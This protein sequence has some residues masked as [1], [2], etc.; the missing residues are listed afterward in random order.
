MIRE[1]T[2]ADI[3]S[4]IALGEAMHRESR[5]GTVSWSTQKVG[6]L[7]TW[8]ISSDD[9]LVLV[10]ERDGEIIGGFLGVVTEHYFSTDKMAQDFALFVSPGR[11]G[12]VAGAQLLARFIA[13]A[14]SRGVMD[15]WIQVGVTT[16]VDIEKTSR[17]C[18][19][20]GFQPAGYLFALKE[21]SPCA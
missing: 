1:A 10:A 7:I 18:Q 21:S 14:R 11:R 4:L 3:H 19:A 13:W 12:G 9:G 17:L 20:V 15:E 16:G 5:F 8:L 2:E 6:D